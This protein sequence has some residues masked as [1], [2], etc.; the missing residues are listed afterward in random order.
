MK[1]IENSC[2]TGAQTQSLTKANQNNSNNNGPFSPLFE[3]HWFRLVPGAHFSQHGT[4]FSGHHRGHQIYRRQ[5]AVSAANLLISL[6]TGV[7]LGP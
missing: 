1:S 6:E 3:N 2:A 7:A 4:L 5:G